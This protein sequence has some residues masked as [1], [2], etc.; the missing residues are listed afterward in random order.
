M[1]CKRCT[2]WRL[3][4]FQESKNRSGLLLGKE[5]A[6]DGDV[7]SGLQHSLLWCWHFSLRNTTTESNIISIQSNATANITF[8]EVFDSQLVRQR[9][10]PYSGVEGSSLSSRSLSFPCL[11]A[12]CPAW[13]KGSN[14]ILCCECNQKVQSKEQLCYAP[15]PWPMTTGRWLY[16]FL[17]CYFLFWVLLF[18]SF[19]LFVFWDMI[20]L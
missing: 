9:L 16:G 20:S 3:F 10:Q 4:L 14:S 15:L 8:I 18:L 13:I 2:Q 1:G 6:I 12:L 17:I 7:H 5:M 11:S 19:C